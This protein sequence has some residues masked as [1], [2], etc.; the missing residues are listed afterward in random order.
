M[1][2]ELIKNVTFKYHNLITDPINGQYDIIF[3]RNVMI[4]FDAPSKSALVEKFI[5]VLKPGGYFI[6]GSFDSVISE[7]LR[8][9]FDSSLANLRIFKKRV[10]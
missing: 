1:D 2:K 10:A 3:C 9:Q 7:D 4:Y 5:N 8:N 6:I